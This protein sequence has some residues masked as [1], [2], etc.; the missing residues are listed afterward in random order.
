MG[1]DLPGNGPGRWGRP[2]GRAYRAAP[3]VV[4]VKDGAAT[5]VV[6]PAAGHSWAL[7]GLEAATWDLLVL[8]YQFERAA[9]LLAVLGDV[10][11]ADARASLSATLQRWEKAG[12][13]LAE[14][15]NGRDEPGD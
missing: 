13:L 6:N 9:R 11:E 2:A 14:K 10:T 7:R 5:L 15:G 4:W 8:G 1:G 12:I 3:G